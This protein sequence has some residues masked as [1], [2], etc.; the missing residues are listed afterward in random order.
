MAALAVLTRPDGVNYVAA[1]ALA[2][3]LTA[4]RAN[5]RRRAVASLISVAAFVSSAGRITC[6]ASGDL[7]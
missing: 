4:H 2:A 3:V 7:R 1:F 5:I 6:L